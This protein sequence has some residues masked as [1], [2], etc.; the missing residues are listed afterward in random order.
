MA[1]GWVLETRLPTLQ[2]LRA[3]AALAVVG[4]HIAQ[5]TDVDFRIGQAGVDLFF[6]I[7]GAVMWISAVDKDAPPRHALAQGRHPPPDLCD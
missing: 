5:W 7:S 3:I 1:S 4:F 2:S 6:V